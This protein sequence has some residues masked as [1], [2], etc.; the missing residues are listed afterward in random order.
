MIE[1]YGITECGPIVTLNRLDEPR[2]GVGKPIPHME[3]CIIDSESE[4]QL[5]RGEEG[6]ICIYGPSV[7]PGYL[8]KIPSPFIILNGKRW[9][10]SGDR[11][12]IDKHG[13]L[14]LSERLK[15]FIK[16]GGEMVSLSGLE[17]ELHHQAKKHGWEKR[18][19]GEKGPLFAIGVKEKDTDKPLIVLF[20]TIELSKDEVNSVLK[21]C[22]YGKIIK[23]AEVKRVDHIP[24]TGTG[25]VHY[26]LLDEATQ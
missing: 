16:I 15:R 6:E 7:F 3:L 22:G 23:I 14:I 2:V 9:Y 17:E 26:R 12:H 19:K 10:R 18:K 1:G 11:G 21:S 8:G 4:L 5:E 13:N 24:M 20:T 25:K